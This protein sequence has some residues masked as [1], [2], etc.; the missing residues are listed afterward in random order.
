MAHE[1]IQIEL[2][3]EVAAQLRETARSV[4]IADIRDA[5][6]AAIGEWVARY[7]NSAAAANADEKYFV[8]QAL[9]DLAAK[10]RGD[11]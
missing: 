4:G 8:N 6:A 9:D 7:G 5:I 2:S 1:L 10:R 3:A 11:V